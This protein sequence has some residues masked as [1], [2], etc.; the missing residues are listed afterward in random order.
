MYMNATFTFNPNTAI[1]TGQQKLTWNNAQYITEFA[2]DV[3]QVGLN[4]ITATITSN[5]QSGFLNQKYTIPAP[6]HACINTRFVKYKNYESQ[7]TFKR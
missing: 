4:D 3:N 7:K 6:K 1:I 2:D 5:C